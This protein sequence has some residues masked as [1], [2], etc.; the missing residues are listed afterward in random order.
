VGGAAISK[1]LGFFVVDHTVGID[2]C[3][4]THLDVPHMVPAHKGVVVVNMTHER[5]RETVVRAVRQ[6]S[7]AVLGPAVRSYALRHLAWVIIYIE[8]CTKAPVR[9]Q[10]IPLNTAEW[11]M[12]STNFVEG[13]ASSIASQRGLQEQSI[14]AI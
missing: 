14:E 9:V 7:I 5:G 12:Y 3:V 10:D 1:A 8:I 6:E 2:D 11:R 4:I 13:E